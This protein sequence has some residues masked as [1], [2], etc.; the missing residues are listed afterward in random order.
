MKAV[1]EKQKQKEA[2]KPPTPAPA[3]PPASQIPWRRHAL[4]LGALVLAALLA[5]SNSFSAGFVFDNGVLMKDSRIKAVTSDNLDLIWNQE[6]WYNWSISGLYRP[7]STLSYLFNY[8]ILGN[9]EH[10]AGYHWVNFSLHSIN[11]ALV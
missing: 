7:L 5:Y 4:L 8:A 11:I 6:Y 10:P 2:P 3:E 9:A 1:R